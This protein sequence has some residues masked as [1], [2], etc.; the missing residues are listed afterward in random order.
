MFLIKKLISAE[1]KCRFKNK[2]MNETIRPNYNQ[3]E[4]I[5]VSRFDAVVVS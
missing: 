5:H 2:L 3:V 4:Q 1:R